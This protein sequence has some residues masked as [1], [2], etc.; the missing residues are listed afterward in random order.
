MTVLFGVAIPFSVL[1]RVF[2]WQSIGDV[3]PYV[4]ET[5]TFLLEGLKYLQVKVFKINLIG[6]SPQ[7]TDANPHP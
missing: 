6:R 2:V 3:Q 1:A 4:Q 7:V 5:T